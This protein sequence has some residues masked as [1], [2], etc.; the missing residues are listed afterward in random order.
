MA[1]DKVGKVATFL[2]L[3]HTV[4]VPEE[5]EEV[6]RCQGCPKGK[7]LERNGRPLEVGAQLAPRLLVCIYCVF[8]HLYISVFVN[9]CICVLLYLCGRVDCVRVI[10]G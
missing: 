2:C 4:W 10:G 5:R 8:V 7:K 3:G 6:G 1:A 9:F